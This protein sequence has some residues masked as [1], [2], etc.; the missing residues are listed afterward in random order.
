MDSSDPRFDLGDPGETPQK[1]FDGWAEL[2]WAIAELHLMAA[3]LGATLGS[4][5][6]TEL[7]IVADRGTFAAADLLER[8]L[9]DVGTLAAHYLRLAIADRRGI[10]P[11]G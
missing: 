2:R 10:D 8:T 5:D 7:W 4:D 11:L 9:A 3:K 6:E 1:A